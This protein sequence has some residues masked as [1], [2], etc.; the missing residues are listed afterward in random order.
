MHGGLLEMHKGSFISTQQK[1]ISY[2]NHM[3]PV[4]PH[5]PHTKEGWIIT[6]TDKY[7]GL[8]ETL[9]LL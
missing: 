7:C 8:L 1:W 6:L 4:K 2:Q 3:W 9:R 5:I